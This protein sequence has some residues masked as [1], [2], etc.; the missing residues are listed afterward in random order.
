MN[1]EVYLAT[2]AQSQIFQRLKKEIY[3]KKPALATKRNS[4]GSLTN[5]NLISEPHT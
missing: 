5:G 3:K 4:F 2:P 1:T